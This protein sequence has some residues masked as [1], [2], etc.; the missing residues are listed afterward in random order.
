MTRAAVWF[1]PE[2]TK[3]DTPHGA[4]ECLDMSLRLDD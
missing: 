3:W 4:N 2:T 1:G